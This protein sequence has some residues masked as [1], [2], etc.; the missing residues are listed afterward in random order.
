MQCIEQKRGI[1]LGLCGAPI[2]S[3]PEALWPLPRRYAAGAVAQPAE[4]F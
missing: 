4:K 1:L 3:A 2:D